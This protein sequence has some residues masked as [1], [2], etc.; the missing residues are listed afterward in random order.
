LYRGSFPNIF[1]LLGQRIPL[2]IL[3]TSLNK[4]SL[5]RDSTVKLTA[6][7]YILIIE[8]FVY[9]ARKLIVIMYILIRFLANTSCFLTWHNVLDCAEYDT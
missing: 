8:T 2:V 9:Y 7:G 1:L 5:Y 4:G 3:R 6:V